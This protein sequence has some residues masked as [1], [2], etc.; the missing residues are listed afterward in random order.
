MYRYFTLDN[1]DFKGKTIGIRVDINS[2]I[3]NKK[4]ILN[5]RISKSAISIKELI[6]RGAK[7]VIL[8]HQGIEGKDD[9]VSLKEHSK[10]LSKEVGKEINFTNIIPNH[11]QNW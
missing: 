6:E 9:C 4:V 2:P 10:L 3:I 11:Y 7:I 1:F 5:E 8:A